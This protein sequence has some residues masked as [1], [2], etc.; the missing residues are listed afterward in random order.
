[1]N[2]VFHLVLYLSQLPVVWISLYSKCLCLCVCGEEVNRLD[3]QPGGK[4]TAP[5]LVSPRTRY[6]DFSVCACVLL[7][8]CL[9]GAVGGRNS[10]SDPQLIYHLNVK[11]TKLDPMFVCEPVCKTKC[12]CVCVCVCV[13]VGTGATGLFLLAHSN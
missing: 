10:C 13:W 2:V 7:P 8:G 12:A 9:S 6:G 3:D 1:M 4:A 5:Y 11:G